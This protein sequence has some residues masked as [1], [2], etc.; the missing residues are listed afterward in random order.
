MTEIFTTIKKLIE[1]RFKILKSEILDEISSIAARVGIILLMV[2]SASFILLFGSIALA[3]YFSELYGS[4]SVGFL[5]LTGIY[6][7][8]FIILYLVRNANFIQTGLKNSLSRYV[9]LFKSKKD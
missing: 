2:L 9:F 5:L 3:F 1:V 7:L 6:F 4:T 8:L